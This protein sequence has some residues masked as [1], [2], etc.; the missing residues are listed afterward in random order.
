M[1]WIIEYSAFESLLG[2]TRALRDQAA[3]HRVYDSFETLDH[4]RLFMEHHVFAVWDFM[5]LVKALQARLTTVTVPWL[6]AGDPLSRRLINEIVL[7]EES[8]EDGQGGYSSHFELYLHAMSDCGADTSRI[9]AFTEMLA[10]GKTVPD[11]LRLADAPAAA[12]AFV[13]TTWTIVES[14]SP[15]RIAAAFTL[16]REEIVPAMFQG[17][18]GNIQKRFPNRMDRFA[19]YLERHIHIDKDRHAPMAAR[20]LARLCADDPVRCDE[21]TQAAR[22][23]LRA[24]IALWDDVQLKIEKSRPGAETLLKCA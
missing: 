9:T 16:G 21:A 6:P 4:V 12:R 10:C 11:A 17:V 19:Y 7:D 3:S 22:T 18:I 8:D 15:H 20:M 23:A 1:S 14:R 24:R 13:E 5:S 2:P